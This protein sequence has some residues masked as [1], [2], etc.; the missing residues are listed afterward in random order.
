[1]RNAIIGKNQA[2]GVHCDGPCTLEFVWYVSVYSRL[3]EDNMNNRS[4]HCYRFEDVCEDA[5]TGTFKSP[6]VH[7]TKS[8]LANESAIIS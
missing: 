8:Q 4:H 2:E 3:G 7:G 6:I 1:M 5:I